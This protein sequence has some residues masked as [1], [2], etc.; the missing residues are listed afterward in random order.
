MA[1]VRVF[2]VRMV[3]D[4]ETAIASARWVGGES[5]RWFAAPDE[6]W[7]HLTQPAAAPEGPPPPTPPRTPTPPLEDPIP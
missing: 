7:T 5:E 1:E 4:R 3:V 6:L 2:V